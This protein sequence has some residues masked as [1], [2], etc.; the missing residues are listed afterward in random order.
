M[1]DRPMANGID[2]QV[3]DTAGVSGLIAPK[4]I[5]PECESLSEVGN[6]R[7]VGNFQNVVD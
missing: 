7:D 1:L 4:T 5:A 2:H 6:N 3:I